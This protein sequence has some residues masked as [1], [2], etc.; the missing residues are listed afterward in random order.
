[1]EEFL[2]AKKGKVIAVEVDAVCTE[3][4]KFVKGL[5]ILLWKGGMQ[6]GRSGGRKHWWL[7]GEDAGEISKSSLVKIKKRH[8]SFPICFS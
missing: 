2:L 6:P 3:S 8:I 4:R 5:K 7:V 1:M